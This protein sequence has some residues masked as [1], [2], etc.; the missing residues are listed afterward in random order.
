MF[1]PTIAEITNLHSLIGSETIGELI[2]R[3]YTDSVSEEIDSKAHSRA[4]YITCGL[5]V[6]E[7]EEIVYN[8]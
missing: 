8:N 6:H 7:I 1:R 5:R 2:I 4:G 3:D